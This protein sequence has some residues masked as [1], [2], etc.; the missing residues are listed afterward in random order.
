MAQLG[1]SLPKDL[2]S[3]RAAIEEVLTNE[4]FDVLDA[5][6]AATGRDFLLKI[7]DLI[8]SVPLG[9]ALIHEDMRPST[10]A[11]VY[12]ELGV[13]QAYGKETL[14]VK[15]EAAAIPSDFVRTE[16]LV[17]GT[18]FRKALQKFVAGLQERVDYYAK[19]AGLTEN[20]PLLAL[21]YHRRAYLLSRDDIHR[22]RAREVFDSVG[23]EGRA[24][25]SVE[26]LMAS[27]LE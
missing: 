20:N 15:T 26:M 3:A 24:K 1:E 18:G 11:N 12:Y 21:D 19:L 9:I 17:A 23:T 14:I 27:F 6:S 8:L 22:E 4:G 5:T 13:M 7:W 2:S 25:N 10:T 16:Y